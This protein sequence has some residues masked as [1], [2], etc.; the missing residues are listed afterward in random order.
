MRAD[1]SGTAGD[2]STISGEALWWP[3]DKLAGRYLAPYLSRQVGDAADVHAPDTGV[4]PVEVTFDE[5]DSGALGVL[6]DLT[7]D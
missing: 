2:D 4:V 3:P 1:I 6:R 5:D 7:A